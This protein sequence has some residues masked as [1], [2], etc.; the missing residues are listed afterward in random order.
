MPKIVNHELY[1][2]E[3]LNK[4]F[5]LFS[6]RGFSN[7]SM[8][9]IAK[10]LKISTGTLYHYF[11]S[12]KDIFDSLVIQVAD[13]NIQK[14]MEENDRAIGFEERLDLF[15]DFIN[16][17]LE[18][19]IKWLFIFF[20]YKLFNYGKL[21]PMLKNSSETY[22]KAISKFLQIEDIKISN[23]I[24]SYLNGIITTHLVNDKYFD[25]QTQMKLLKRIILA[26]AKKE[27]L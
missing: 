5:N 10:E 24:F 15:L 3:L 12:K 4:C 20:D 22:C 23:F 26:M 1:R 18:H 19:F 16:S 21:N 9:Q 27:I 17:N 25:I 6:V 14:I 13:S 7:L 8:R 11:S 2:K